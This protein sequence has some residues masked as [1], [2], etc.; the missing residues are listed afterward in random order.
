MLNRFIATMAALLLILSTIPLASHAAAAEPTVYI[1]GHQLMV[2]TPP[3]IVKGTTLVPLR[4]I[5]EAL[6]AE[7]NWDGATQ[8]VTAIKGE[9]TISLNVGQRTV[10]KNNQSIIGRPSK[11]VY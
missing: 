2:D 10:F 4:A 7:I 11:T 6:G 9:I 3:T 5:L 1:D 8:T